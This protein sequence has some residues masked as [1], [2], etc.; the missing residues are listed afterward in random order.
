[1]V[2]IDPG[3]P[4]QSVVPQHSYLGVEDGTAF[5]S[6]RARSIQRTAFVHASEQLNHAQKKEAWFHHLAQL[7]HMHEKK[8]PCKVHGD[9]SYRG[10]RRPFERTLS[11]RQP[12][13]A[14]P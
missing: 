3:L 6:R 10:G 2:H 9:E 11:K 7:L 5:L 1:M 8:Q 14:R 13:A 12:N 4:C